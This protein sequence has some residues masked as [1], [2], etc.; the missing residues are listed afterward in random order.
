M[1]QEWLDPLLEL[2][3]RESSYNP[4]ADNP[5]SSA[6]GLF[7]FLDG[8]RKNYGGNKVDWSDPYQQ[9]LA[10]IQYVTDRYGNPTK[11]LQFWDKNKWY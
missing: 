7:Q 4:N 5:K 11:A 6:A 1:S 8:T 2:V 10:G 3:G 9:T